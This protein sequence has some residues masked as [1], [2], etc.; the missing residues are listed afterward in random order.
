VVAWDSGWEETKPDDK[1]AVIDD[2]VFL[3]HADSGAE[4]LVAFVTAD[5]DPTA[6]RD[7]AFSSSGRSDVT[8]SQLE[9]GEY[10][11]VAYS[12]EL[13]RSEGDGAEGVF[14]LMISNSA[15]GTAVVFVLVTDSEAF[16]EG[17]SA[18]QAGVTIDGS[19]AMNGVDPAGMQNFLN[20]AQSTSTHTTES[21]QVPTTNVVPT[22]EPAQTT[23]GSGNTFTSS[24]WGYTVEYSAPFM[25]VSGSSGLEFMIATSSPI[26]VVGFMGIENPGV[27]PSAIF[28][29][30]TPTFIENLGS[31]G[32]YFDG[33]FSGDRAFWAGFTSDGNQMVQQI[34]VVSPSTVV[35][36]SILGQPGVNLSTVGDVR[37]NGISIFGN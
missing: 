9:A 18:V 7:A 6:V 31:G 36:V 23:S 5:Q 2:S 20:L 21:V 14:T 4:L 32:S 22:Q 37:L 30:L 16:S 10:G 11:D 28:E 25:D 15:A 33:G 26:V 35:I 1:D 17:V 29:A 13:L 19:A 3:E 34:V 8:V 12:V 27:P 24:T